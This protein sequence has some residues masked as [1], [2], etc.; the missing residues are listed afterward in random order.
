LTDPVVM[1][2]ERSL[3]LFEEACK[4]IPGGVNTSI[5]ILNP[6]IVFTKAKG[7]RI[8]DADGNEYIDYHAAFGPPILGHNN[9][10]VN[11][12]VMEI[13]SEIDL[14]GV[15]TAEIEIKAAELIV[16]NVPSIEKVLFCN[17]GS[18]ATYHAVR[19]ARAV[20]GRKKL[21]KFQGCYHGWH[22]YLLMNVISPPDKIGKKDPL[23]AGM[24]PEA[25]ENTL[26]VEFNDLEGVERV[27]KVYRNEI[28]AI[29][30]EPIQHNIGCV[31]PIMDFLKGLREI[32]EREGIVLIFDEVIT[33]F[34]HSI[35]GY[36]KITG[37][38][39]DITTLGKAMANGYPLAAVGGRS[40]F[41]DRFNTKLGGDVFFAGTYN[42]HPISLAACIATIEKLEDGKVYQHI[43]R[44]GEIMRE[45]LSDIT[46]ELGIQ[47]YTTGFGSVF[48][49]YFME[50]PVKNYTDLLRNDARLFVE[51]RKRMIE[52]GIFMLPLNLKRNHISAAHTEE[53]IKFTLDKSREVLKEIKE[54]YKK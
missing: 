28:A 17:S 41:M 25:V 34:R 43:F 37:V 54:I 29:I 15:G 46:E 36:Q 31:L 32:T 10:E 50:P 6:P 5:R 53:E 14:I 38:I 22:D 45:G 42:A 7:S 19:L 27:V 2:Y 13:M 26:I 8:Y 20:T 51:Y 11:R 47:A 52:K 12:R 35:G 16:K 30:L 23:S 44:L 49:T 24:L 33:G 21:I 39:P 3:R 48:V 1:R 18:E 4:Y 9:P 40:D